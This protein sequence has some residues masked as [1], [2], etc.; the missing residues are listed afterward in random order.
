MKIISIL[1]KNILKLS[2]NFQSTFKLKRKVKKILLCLI[3]EQKNVN[4]LFIGLFSNI[5]K[6]TNI[7]TNI[8][9]FHLV[10]I[11]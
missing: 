8:A 10:K 9:K 4:R 7:F 1:F 3:Y 5:I 11:E 6:W 2:K